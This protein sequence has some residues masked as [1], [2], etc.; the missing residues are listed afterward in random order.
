MTFYSHHSNVMVKWECY[1]LM[2]CNSHYE[3]YSLCWCHKSESQS[4]RWDD[5]DADADSLCKFWS[6]F[7]LNVIIMYS[8]VQMMFYSF[9]LFYT[10]NC[11]F[12]C[13]CIILWTCFDFVPSLFYTRYF[14]ITCKQ[15]DWLVSFDFPSS[16]YVCVWIT[17]I[18]NRY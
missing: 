15:N 18:I 12:E 6:S 1:C 3:I 7:Q 13:L 14:E 17:K 4:G 10:I 8:I 16:L 5:I 11:C 9:S 2:D